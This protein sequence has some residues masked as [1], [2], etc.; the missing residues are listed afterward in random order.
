MTA[1]KIEKRIEMAIILEG[2]SIFEK[3]MEFWEVSIF[4]P[5]P[6]ILIPQ[7]FIAW[8]SPAQ[9]VRNRMRHRDAPPC[10]AIELC[11][12]AVSRRSANESA[13]PRV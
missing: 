3:G 9:A 8:L 6:P 7:V 5:P 1:N 11:H 12:R 13:A 4:F 2:G 10:R